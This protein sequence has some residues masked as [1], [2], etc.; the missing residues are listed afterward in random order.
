MQESEYEKI[1]A[2]IRR[3][4]VAKGWSQKELAEKCGISLNFI[5][6][7]ERGTRH[8]SLDTFVRLCKVLETSADTLLWDYPRIFETEMQSVWGQTAEMEDN[9]YAMYVKILKSVADILND[10][11]K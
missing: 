2:R 9:S 3:I 1:G 10:K 11:S 7:M 6:Y 8:M 5:G 4:R